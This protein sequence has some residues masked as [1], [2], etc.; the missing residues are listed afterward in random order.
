M[1][2]NPVGVEV[3][4]LSVSL[5]VLDIFAVSLRLYARW[6]SKAAFGADDLMIVVS[7]VPSY[8]MI[9]I[10]FLGT[11]ILIILSSPLTLRSR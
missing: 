9:I 7:L 10:G 2:T 5:G 3:K 4:R 1:A 8:C 11:R 6:K